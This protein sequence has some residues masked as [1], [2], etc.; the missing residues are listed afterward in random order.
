MID[1][2]EGVMADKLIVLRAELAT[3][4][5]RVFERETEIK[6][7]RHAHDDFLKDIADLVAAIQFLIGAIDN[8]QQK[9]VDKGVK[10]VLKELE[11]LGLD[12]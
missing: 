8:G 7:L 9:H 6:L 3:L 11:D 10:D 5:S 4:Q 1:D 12:S 2:E